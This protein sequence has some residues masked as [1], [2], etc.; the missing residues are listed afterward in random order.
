MTGRGKDNLPGSDRHGADTE[1]PFG[2]RKELKPVIRQWVGV[3]LAPKD[4]AASDLAEIEPEPAPEPTLIIE[5]PT[6]RWSGADVLATEPTLEGGPAEVSSTTVAKPRKEFIN[7]SSASALVPYVH[8]DRHGKTFSGEP[9][10]PAGL[11]GPTVELKV[12]VA[13]EKTFIVPR[14]EGGFLK[15]E[16]QGGGL[17]RPTMRQSV[18]V[19]AAP[20]AVTVDTTPPQFPKPVGSVLGGDPDTLRQGVVS[21]EVIVPSK[22]D[23]PVRVGQTLLRG[24]DLEDGRVEL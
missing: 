9:E 17:D 8:V 23:G 11:T 14:G 15:H 16:P 1:P 18:S 24:T 21:P 22:P 2:T 3:A 5:N 4:L 20:P 19:D 12:G 10:Q 7:P 13:G 6:L